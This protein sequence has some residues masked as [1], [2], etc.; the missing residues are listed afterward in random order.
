MSPIICKTLDYSRNIRTQSCNHLRFRKIDLLNHMDGGI[1]SIRPKHAL[2]LVTL[3]LAVPALS[4]VWGAG[5]SSFANAA[6]TSAPAGTPR[7]PLALLFTL[8]YGLFSPQCQ[9]HR[10]RKRRCRALAAFNTGWFLLR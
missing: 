1:L 3:M 8:D 7:S 5:C 4:G 9:I 2:T 10:F 6:S